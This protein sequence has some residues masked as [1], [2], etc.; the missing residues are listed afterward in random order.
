MKRAKRFLSILLTLC[1]VLGMFPGTVFAAN[2]SVPFTDVKEADWFY[3]A[4]QYVYE[5]GMMSGTGA[6]TFSPDTTTTRC[7]IVTILH[8]MEGTPSATGAEFTDVPADQYYSD[9][10]AWASANGIVSGYG[11]GIFG[12]NDTIT[13]EQ[14]ATIL[15]RYVQYKGYD[16]ETTGDVSTFADGSQVSSY[17]V[18]AMN[19]AV[20]SGLISGVGNNT[21]APKGS[22]TRAQVAVILMRF[23]NSVAPVSYTVTFEY[24]YGN[25][26]V[27]QTVTVESGETVDKPANPTRSGYSFEGWYTAETNGEKF[28]FDTVIDEDITLYAQWHR[29]SSGSGVVIPT[30]TPNPDPTPDPTIYY[31]VTFE[32]NGGNEIKSVQVK[33]GL[34]LSA[35]EDPVREEYIFVGW[36]TSEELDEMFLFGVDVI[37]ADTT[38]YAAWVY[39]DE[40]AILAEYVARQINIGYQQGDSADHV[41]QNVTLPTEVEGV[42]GVVITW[43]S[44][45]DT[46][47]A[48]GVV[49]RPQ[50]TDATVTLTV[51]TSK[52]EF[53]YNTEFILTVI[54]ENDRNRA[55]IS[56]SS[57]IDIENMNPDGGT[58]ISFNEDKTQVI[59]IEGQYSDIVVENADDALDV[60]QSVHTILGIN[61]PYE[62]LDTLVINS[63]EYGAEYT[64]AQVYNGYQVYGRKITVSVDENGIT[65]SLSSGICASVKLSGVNSVP[66]I[67]AEA[68]ETV[69][70]SLYGGECTV[71]STETVLAYYALDEFSDVPVLVYLIHVTGSNTNGE[72]I[73]ETVFVNTNDCTV[74]ATRTSIIDA[75]T[76]TGSGKNELGQKVSFPVAFTWTDWYFYYMQDLNR[77]IQMYEKDFLIDFRIGSELNWW[78]DKTAISAYTNIIKTY[79]WYKNTLNR[80]SLDGNGLAIKVIVDVDY[81]TDNAFWSGSNLTLN[82][83]DNSFGSELNTTT[84]AA[85]DVAAHEYT[86]GVVQFVTGGLRYEDA[87]GAINEGY[88]DIFGCLVDGDW[89][90]GEDWI[91]I[92]DASNP[93][94]Y[95]DPDKMSSSFYIDYTTDSTDHGGVHTNSALVYHAAYLMSEYGMSKT[96]L[97]KLWYKSLSMGY[98]D[99]STFQTVRQNV[100]KAARK[101]ALS[102][103]EIEIIKKAFDAVEIYG[104]QGE[105]KVTVSDTNGNPISGAEV[106]IVEKGVSL[107]EV[108]NSYNLKLDE[109]IYSLKVSADGYVEYNANIEIVEEETTTVN[110]VLVHEG[111]GTVSGKVVSAT[112][113]LTLEGVSM[114]ARSGINVQ[115]GDVVAT[116]QTDG[117]GQYSMEL[118]AGYYTIEMVL[119]GYT[120]GYVNIQVDGGEAATA[121]ASLSPVMSS[122]TYRV[123]LTW[124]ASPSD[125]DSHLSGFAADGTPFHI[126]FGDKV[127][128]NTNGVEI[129]NLDVDDT[130]SYG[131][132]TTTFIAE[133]EGSS[134]FSVYRYSSSGSLPASGATVEVYNGDSLIA[135]YTIDSSASNN[136]RYWN[137]FKIENGI[138]QTIDTVSSSATTSGISVAT[139]SNEAFTV[140]SLPKN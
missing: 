41:T 44:S 81:Q 86:H 54:H 100:L 26:G 137:V 5:N 98:D 11:N 127:A 102:N 63:D 15:Y 79:D 104:P 85:L 6:S 120:T 126:Y 97:A 135:R 133:T 101:I 99:T 123:V 35:P 57:V 72:Y 19:W 60:I 62:E 96:T 3:D 132:E 94:A 114:S 69:A 42:E 20:G 47:S 46:I 134:Y 74:V 25:K 67:T 52:N 84:A 129:G 89:Q 103:S 112:S 31:T 10:V 28:D 136:Y 71:D 139:Y 16:A 48:D 76:K 115:S 61:D 106:T 124:G 119:D 64:F 83:C 4:V 110:V 55:D 18:E 23:C 58:D 93:T 1:M 13:R 108:N 107:N 130:T 38:L 14:M 53:S 140:D 43:S 65:D 49:T 51:T 7:M 77:D 24:N 131:P 56:N 34:T 121:N 66:Q 91:L 113:A 138:F 87:P 21:L 27:Y 75:S 73:D 125:L 105:I 82:F 92:R 39:D 17:A 40:D 32:T 22:A 33:E 122:N 88:A 12:P 95:G 78:T 8:R 45:S 37:T 36:Y 118:V 50:S 109:G 68:A 80:N 116:T 29:N 9:A 70:L 2:S 128:Y 111:N 30:P 117:N 90:M 59:S